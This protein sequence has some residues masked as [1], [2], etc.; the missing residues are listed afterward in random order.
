MPSFQNRAPYIKL[1]KFHANQD[2]SSYL[3]KCDFQQKLICEFWDCY[4]IHS[5]EKSLGVVSDLDSKSRFALH[6]KMRQT[7][8]VNF[9]R[10]CRKMWLFTNGFKYR[11]IVYYWKAFLVT[12]VNSGSLPQNKALFSSYPLTKFSV[13]A[14]KYMP[15]IWALLSE[16]EHTILKRR[17]RWTCW[18]PEPLFNSPEDG[19]P[20]IWTRIFAKLGQGD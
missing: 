16:T 4:W 6:V 10:L 2:N 13:F 14:R 9:H 12:S 18:D 8:I 3:K 11:K 17:L 20:L 1:L 19:V 15:T 7:L 5:I